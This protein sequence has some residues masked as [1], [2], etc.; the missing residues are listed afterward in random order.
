MLTIGRRDPGPFA[1]ETV[2]NV[3]RLAG[4]ASFALGIAKRSRANATAAALA[5]RRRL[6]EELHDG[7]SAVLFSIASRTDRLQRR[8]TERELAV[9]IEVLQQELVEAGGLVR[10]L[11]SE[12]HASA[13][14]DLQAEVHGV[15]E[16]FERRTGIVSVAVFLGSVPPLDSARVQALTRFVAVALANVERHTPARRASV[17][18]AALP[19]QITVAVF[20][21]GSAPVELVPGVGLAGAEERIARLGGDVTTIDDEGRKGF[22]IRARLP[23]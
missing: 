19:T 21:D 3:E 6:S 10:S 17:T 20:N 1:D 5:E 2:A 16:E 9:E 14:A 15:V 4:R 18:V 23:L 7:L 22:T 12:W 13:T 11:V 8:T